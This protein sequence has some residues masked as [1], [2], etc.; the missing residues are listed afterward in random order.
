MAVRSGARRGGTWLGIAAV[1]AGLS[2]LLGQTAL[3]VGMVLCVGVLG[4]VQFAL[5]PRAFQGLGD[6]RWARLGTICGALGW[7]LGG[8]FGLWGALS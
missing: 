5:L 6:T 4:Y 8:F 2:A 7:A 3:I 1:V